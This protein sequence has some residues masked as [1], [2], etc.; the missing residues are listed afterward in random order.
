METTPVFLRPRVRRRRLRPLRVLAALL[1]VLLLAVTGISGY[2][3]YDLTH[4]QKK[5]VESSPQSLDMEFKDIEFPS[6]DGLTLRGWFIPAVSGST[7]K[8]V[9]MSHGYTGNRAGDKPALPTAKA[10]RDNGISVLMFDF[11][12]S[13]ASDG[14]MTTVGVM[15]KTDLLQALKFAQGQGY[16]KQGIGFLGFSMGASTTL[17]AGADA[18]EVKALV[19]DSPFADLTDYL[20]ENMPYW[21]H[22]PDIPFTQTILW[23]LPWITGHK[24]SEMSPIGSV[25]KLRNRPILFI[26]GGSDQAINKSNSE[27]ML[28]A[29]NNPQDELWT[30]AGA[31]HV[32][33]YELEPDAYRE[34][35]VEFFLSHL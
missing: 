7:D 29:L 2:V 34:K 17:A 1:V 23:E 31:R 35:V 5:A 33:T 12:N 24:T 22:L 11:R 30:V 20:H 27:K 13:G 10:L 3:G 6:V 9:I 14:E 19:V 32:G 16:G 21:T 28:Q 18:P 15:E 8:L 25:E 26:H 4:P